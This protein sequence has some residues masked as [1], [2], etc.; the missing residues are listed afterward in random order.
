MSTSEPLRPTP[1]VSILKHCEVTRYRHLAAMVEQKARNEE[2]LENLDDKQTQR[3]EESDLIREYPCV[4]EDLHDGRVACR[5]VEHVLGKHQVMAF[6]YGGD[7][8]LALRRMHRAFMDLLE[9]RKAVPDRRTALRI[10]GKSRFYAVVTIQ[11]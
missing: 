6:A 1:G 8:A 5:T 4:F 10:A 11:K 2:R 3:V 9:S 7:R